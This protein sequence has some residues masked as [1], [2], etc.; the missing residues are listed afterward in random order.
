MKRPVIL[1]CDDVLLDWC[2]GFSS[3]MRGAK[4]LDLPGKPHT[5]DLS[6]WTGLPAAETRAAVE[7]FNR[8]IDFAWLRSID[9]AVPALV[10]LCLK[11]HPLFVLT[12][13][14][15]EAKVRDARIENLSRNFGSNILPPDKVF[16]LPLGANK[17]NH[18]RALR[19]LYGSCHWIEDNFHH[20]LDGHAIGHQSIMMRRPHNREHER[21]EIGGTVEW[22][23]D[24]QDA[25]SLLL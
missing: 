23:S 8:S 15:A 1:D 10:D 22:A 14:S 11:G 20:A 13:C 6:H 25:L 7:E 17:Q 16:C 2:D 5:W 12:S 4:G 3:W 9:G 21:S 24:W 19:D 18:L